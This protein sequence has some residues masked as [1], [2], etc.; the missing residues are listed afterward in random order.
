MYDTYTNL[1]RL[2]ENW[3]GNN[4]LREVTAHYQKTED[5]IAF[6]FIF[7]RV[8]KVSLSITK[9][10]FGMTEDDMGSYMTEE[11]HKA[12]MNYDLN[13]TQSVQY[14]YS[15]FLK[16][17]FYSETKS[18]NYNKRKANQN[19]TSFTINEGDSGGELQYQPEDKDNP[20]ERIDLRLVLDKITDLTETERKYCYQVGL[21]TGNEPKDS[22]IARELGVSSS[23]ITQAK[24]KL[25]NKLRP[26]FIQCT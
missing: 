25:I 13:H 19:T 18:L 16:R 9:N 3:E 24:K 20:F 5:P 8:W 21:T 10:F 22:D 15:V 14:F 11:L 23:A 17:R 7:T 12:L 1:K 4:D 6:S 26:Y 2:A